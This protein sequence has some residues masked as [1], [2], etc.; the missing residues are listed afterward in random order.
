MY[1]G[2]NQ[3]GAGYPDS[4]P[5]NPLGMSGYLGGSSGYPGPPNP[6]LPGGGQQYPPY[7]RPGMPPSHVGMIHSSRPTHPPASPGVA[8]EGEVSVN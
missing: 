5:P 4:L 1:V 2:P 8:N 7:H 3:T 6:Y